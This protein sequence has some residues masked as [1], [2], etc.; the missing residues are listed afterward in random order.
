MSQIV[1]LIGHC[2]PDSFLLETTARK[3]LP[4]ADV[5][6]LNDE[7]EV[8][9][10]LSRWSLLLVNRVLDGTFQSE[11]G[12]ALIESLAGE[13]EAPPMILISNFAES[14]EEAE[15]AGAQPGFGKNDLFAADTLERIRTVAR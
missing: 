13:A 9:A 10:G 7:S 11:S 3:A 15:Q 12:I 4:D 6:K 1:A 5:V 2:G 14:Q 8:R